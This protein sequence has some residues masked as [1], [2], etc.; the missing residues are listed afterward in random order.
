MKILRLLLLCA[1]IV[2]CGDNKLTGGSTAQQPV[3]VKVEKLELGRLA[4]EIAADGK[5]RSGQRATVS[6]SAKGRVVRV[7]AKVGDQV[8][9]GQPLVWVEDPLAPSNIRRL[10]AQVEQ[11]RAQLESARINTD[12]TAH[13]KSADVAEA[14]SNVRLAQ[15]GVEKSKSSL[16]SA[17]TELTRKQ[18]LLTKKAIA[19][20]D[21]EKARLTR[22]QTQAD[23]R[24]SEVQLQDAQ[25]KLA[26]AKASLTVDIQRTSV[27]EAEA[28]VRQAEADL[29]SALAQQSQEVIRSPI[30]GRVAEV[31]VQLGQDPSLSSQPLMTIV[32]DSEV[33]IVANF[34]ERYSRRL[35]P[36]LTGQGRSVTDGKVE[37][38]LV[39]ERVDPES[40]LAQVAVEL[41]LQ[42]PGSV[43]LAADSY[44]RVRLQLDDPQGIVLPIGAVS[45]NDNGGASVMLAEGRF[46][47]VR[48]VKVKDQ[49][50][51]TVLVEEGDLKEGELLIVEGQT[52]LPDGSPITYGNSQGSGTK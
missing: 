10:T 23:L 15:I 2:G 22:D 16:Q 48:P 43:D 26:V 14:A 41:R 17:Q 37:I 28:R 47:R 40:K 7:S 6:G 21:V 9:K 1:L 50:E 46:A 29:E 31:N 25:E 11:A 42:N 33:T 52:G 49:D 20:T 39:V 27:S 35:R 34:D 24:S 32:D 19:Q 3:L 30:A 8:E 36:G 38:P 44:V 5:V 18:D 12:Q 51:S 4:S 45:W 13:Q